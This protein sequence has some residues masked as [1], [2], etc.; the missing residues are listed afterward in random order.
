MFIYLLFIFIFYEKQA[1][2]ASSNRPAPVSD[3][4]PV[5]INRICQA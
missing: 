3:A 5:S 2:G 1:S 4:G